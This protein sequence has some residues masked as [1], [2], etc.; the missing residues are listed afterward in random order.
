MK[1]GKILCIALLSV[2]TLSTLE[3]FAQDYQ[4]TQFYSAPTLLNPGFAGNTEHRRIVS[5]YRTQWTSMPGSFSTYNLSYEQFE[6][7]INSGFGMRV[8][9]DRAGAAK[10]GYTNVSLM[11]SYEMQLDYG[12]YFRPGLSVGRS[13][14]SADYSQ[15]VFGD[16]LNRPEA[17]STIE[18]L[19]NPKHSYFDV[20]VGGVMYA[21]DFW[22]GISANHINKPNTSFFGS[23]DELAVLYSAHGGYRQNKTKRDR[24]R[25]RKA[26]VYAFNYKMQY[27]FDQLDIGLYYEHDP[28]IVGFWY[29][30]LPGVK[31]GGEYN[32][33]N[34]DAFSI[35]VGY[36]LDDIKFGYSYDLTISRLISNTGGSH[37]LSMI[38]EWAKKGHGRRR[39]IPCA[40]F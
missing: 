10:L 8:L 4:L 33:L 34:H 5:N 26:I 16:Q 21:H 30:G 27:D 29:R 13:F 32:R 2:W 23:E 22:V 25:T 7:K 24:F 40:R 18:T 15:L 12:L 38:Y 17:S 20:A 11:Y 19:E 14:A 39:V 9:H 1:R 36:H 31:K 3:G 37:E 35:L 28:L 6:S